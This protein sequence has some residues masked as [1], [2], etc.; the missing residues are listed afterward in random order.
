MC[1]NC[2]Q[3][4]E[5]L[6]NFHQRCIKSE[7]R[8]WTYLQDKSEDFKKD[9]KLVDLFQDHKEKENQ[10]ENDNDVQLHI[11]GGENNNKQN[12][13]DS[14]I[15][16]KSSISS[17][18]VL[19]SS[20]AKEKTEKKS[21]NDSLLEQLDT[22][23][24][25]CEDTLSQ[26]N[27]Q[28][29]NKRKSLPVDLNDFV[30]EVSYSSDEINQNAK[31]P[32]NTRNKRKKIVVDTDDNVSQDPDFKVDNMDDDSDD[33]YVEGSEEFGWIPKTR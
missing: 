13:E 20:G 32:Y 14:N 4:L 21:P 31:K 11:H 28:E 30:E 12:K 29:N 19:E 5:K 23:I 33:D 10:S 26:S 7:N 6:F 1:K 22:A 3:L 15:L 17:Q 9:F 18:S 25:S 27:A 2:L 16:E 24:L 8:I